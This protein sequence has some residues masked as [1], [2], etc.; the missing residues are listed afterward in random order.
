MT[1]VKLDDGFPDHPKVVGLSDRAFRVHVRALCYCGRFSPGI[2]RIPSSALR[3]LGATVAV[4][5]ELLSAAL[6]EEVGDGGFQ[7]HDFSEYHPKADHE[8]KAEAGRRGGIASGEARRSRVLPVGSSTDEAECLPNASC[9]VEP[10]RTPV[11]VPS[12]PVPSASYEASYGADDDLPSAVREMRDWILSKLPAKFRNDGMA[13]DEALLFA[14]DYSGEWAA[15]AT[16]TDAVRRRP[17]PK[18]I[19]FPGALR[20]FMP[21]LASAAPAFK[22]VPGGFANPNNPYPLAEDWADTMAPIPFDEAENERRLAAYEARTA[23]QVKP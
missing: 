15:L 7:I 2:G 22:P 4:A 14:Q 17:A 1:W 6:W 8:A 23:A 9:L 12:R 16:A 3:Q 21:P 10:N 19:P 11:P 20:E 5:K 13:W 18:N